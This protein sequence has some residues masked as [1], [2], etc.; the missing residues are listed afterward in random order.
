M[1]KITT[2]SMMLFCSIN[3]IIAQTTRTVD[4]SNGAGAQYSELQLAI[5]EAGTNDT[6]YVHA[7]EI[8]YGDVIINKPLTLIGFTHSS[9]D[10]NTLVNDIE[11]VEGASG[12]RISGIRVT[13]DLFVDSVNQLTDLIFENNYVEDAIAFFGGGAS[14]VLIRGCVVEYIGTFSTATS[15]AG[16]NFTNTLITNNIVNDAIVTLFPESVTIRNNVFLGANVD[17]YEADN[18]NQ[19]VQNCVFLVRSNS[20]TE[21]DINV[22]GVFYDNCLVFNVFETGTAAPLNGTDNITNEDPLFVSAP[23]FVSFDFAFN[24]QLDDYNLQVGSPAIGTGAGGVDIG[25]Y[26]N[27]N[28]VFNNFGLTPGVPIVNIT[29]ITDQVAP[30]AMVEVTIESSSN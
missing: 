23:E 15:S 22:D 7:S 5:D 25:L 18:F 17:N 30:G 16:C 10:K 9:E 20:G 2:L 21:L 8:N 14:D 1:K 12:T 4:N 29:D 28:F 3:F 26:D 6:L 11:L 13:D 19:V 27:I 24:A